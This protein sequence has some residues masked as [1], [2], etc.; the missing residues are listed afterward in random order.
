ME[1]SNIS[2]IV[3]NW[4]KNTSRITLNGFCS[5]NYFKRLFLRRG[6]IKNKII[7]LNNLK[8][9]YLECIDNLYRFIYYRIIL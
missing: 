4:R 3:F 1:L 5:V 8:L 7:T 9:F 6:I 2:Y